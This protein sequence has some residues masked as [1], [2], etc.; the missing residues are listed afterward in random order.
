MQPAASVGLLTRLEYVDR[1]RLLNI[2]QQLHLP[3]LPFGAFH[4]RVHFSDVQC[5]DQGAQDRAV[6]EPNEYL[7]Y[8]YAEEERQIH[9]EAK[10]YHFYDEWDNITNC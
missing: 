10:F 6:E 7:R 8:N 3:I 2:L 1:Q 4:A 9:K 5:F